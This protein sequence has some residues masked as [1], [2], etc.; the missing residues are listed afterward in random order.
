MNRK[1]RSLLE[2][3][4][5][6]RPQE[7]IHFTDEP[8]YSYFL[9]LPTSELKDELPKDISG[10]GLSDS[11]NEALLKS[12]GECIERI[13]TFKPFYKPNLHSKYC[14]GHNFIDPSTFIH[15]SK[16]QLESN[17]DF[18]K[19]IQNQEYNW[20]ESLDFRTGKKV[21]LPSQIV[22]LNA[23]NELQITE[24]I[25]TGVALRDSLESALLYATLEVIERDSFMTSYLKK[26]PL[27]K[28][29]PNIKKLSE[30]VQYLNRYE[31]FPTLFDA[32]SDIGVPVVLCVTLDYSGLSSAVNVGAK[33]HIDPFLAAKGAILESIQSRRLTRLA[34][35][36]KKEKT[37]SK[38][39]INDLEDRYY[40]WHPIERID[41]LKF[42]LD[43][44]EEKGFSEFERIKFSGKEI[45][46]RILSKGYHIYV[47]DLSW[48]ILKEKGFSVVRSTIPE[49]HPLYLD[50]RFK[51][52]YSV[53]AGEIKNDLM[54]KPHPFT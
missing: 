41:D 38:N 40:Y 43:Q 32:T 52:L 8:K 27:K 24:G 18:V 11:S 49:M 5:T 26:E 19:E 12:I 14:E 9:T 15:F 22:F 50:E 54:L 42:W 25:T 13:C 33:A 4:L 31:L 28:I 37:F 10:Q 2:I 46:R 45:F 44:D 35:L 1:L 48:P 53:H 17:Q 30:I 34:Y 21:L 16:G 23:H 36:N 6:G 47:S 39:H 20:T 7:V 51:A 29:K 3:G